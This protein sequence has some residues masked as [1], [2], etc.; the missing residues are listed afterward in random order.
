MSLVALRHVESSWT[1]DQTCIPCIGRQIL[2]H[3]AT[4]EVPPCGFLHFEKVS[5]KAF[6]SRP[7]LLSVHLSGCSYQ[8][9]LSSPN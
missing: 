5:P 1:R 7:A 8:P 2:N 4:R 9:T 3:C 6:P